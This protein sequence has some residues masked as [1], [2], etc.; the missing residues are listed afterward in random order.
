MLPEEIKRQLDIYVK[1]STERDREVLL[2]R[3]VDAALDIAHCDCG[4]LY[5]LED[6]RLHFSRLVIRS[7]GIRQGGH[8]GP[9]TLPPVS[10]D[11]SNIRTTSLLKCA[12]INL[13][14]LYADDRFPPSGLPCYD[15]MLGYSTRS[16]LV[17]PLNDDRGQL[18]GILQLSNA[19]SPENEVIA[20]DPELE[21]LIWVLASLA[22]ANLTNMQYSERVHDLLDS[23]VESL[24]IAID[25][26]IPYNANHT[27][28]MI[29]CATAFL[30][31]LEQSGQ[32]WQFSPDD[33][34][35]FLMSVW[36]HDI[37]KLAVSLDILDKESRL[38]T[39]LNTVEQR[40]TIIRLLGRLS[41]LENRI[42][43]EAFHTLE[44][45]LEDG[46]D[47][48]HRVN[49][50]PSLTNEDVAAVKALAAHTYLDENG[51]SQPW[52]TPEE[53]DALSIPKGTLTDAERRSMENHVVI[54]ARILEHVSFPE[55]Y[56]KVP[57]WASAHHEL[58]NGT[59]YPNHRTAETLPREVRLLTILDVFD[60]LTASDRPYKSPNSV[61]EALCTLRGMAAEGSLDGDILALF[62]Q[63]RAWEATE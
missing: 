6:S 33:R 57:E 54:T 28:N 14:E 52:L 21:P 22:A 48:I 8:D 24:S 39:A 42:D 62:E 23:L 44:T 58:L 5:L 63:S 13:P 50:A 2:T 55:E 46:L 35:A 41:L 18:I 38:S 31:W 27:R 40:F 56:A 19:L 45:Q 37:G 30:N 7:L 4:T 29:R 51:V 20:F 15:A 1:L 53:T 11:F 26:R 9:V 59:G 36:L 49:T 10:P 17:Y 12:P 60:A 61:E 47:L 25:Q 34:R 3:I 43:A 16:L 32:D